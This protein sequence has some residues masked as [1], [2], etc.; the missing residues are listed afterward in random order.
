MQFLAFC[1]LIDDLINV[2]HWE[3][4]HSKDWIQ[5]INNLYICIF[6]YIMYIYIYI[7]IG[8]T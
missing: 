4:E 2:C 1:C 3:F 7:V 8:A 5:V 6:I